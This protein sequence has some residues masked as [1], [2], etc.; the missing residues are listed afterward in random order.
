MLGNVGAVE[1]VSILV[2]LALVIAPS[3]LLTRG[4]YLLFSRS[5]M[6]ECSQLGACVRAFLLLVVGIAGCHSAPF[7]A[8]EYGADGPLAGSIE[9]SQLTV[10][11]RPLP[12]FTTPVGALGAPLS[13]LDN[14]SGLLYLYRR[15]TVPCLQ[16]TLFGRPACVRV[17]RGDSLVRDS[18]DVC[19]GVLPPGGGSRRWE[20]CD[21]RYRHDDSL[22][23]IAGA[24]MNDRG[25][26]LYVEATGPTDYQFPVTHHADLWLADSATPLS[27]RRRLLTLYHDSVGISTIG[28]QEINWLSQTVWAESNTFLAL[29]QQLHPDQTLSTVAIVAGAVGASAMVLTPLPGTASARLLA[30]AQHAS[31]VVFVREGSR[32]TLESVVRNGGSARVVAVLPVVAGRTIDDIAGCLEQICYLLVGEQQGTRS[33]LWRVNLGSGAADSLRAF[34]RRYTGGRLEPSTGRMVATNGRLYLFEQVLP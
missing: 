34:T 9:G 15:P 29:G 4:V 23:V 30:L 2:T 26:L 24:A 17:A 19:V 5:S 13:W 18:L 28:P 12:L 7:G 6:G 31:S 22:D 20:F 21:T 33:S 10:E 14:G 32:T 27:P 1:I 11:F 3:L 25:Q 16:V 8:A